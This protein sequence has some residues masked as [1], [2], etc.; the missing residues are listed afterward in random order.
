MPDHATL[1]GGP[2]GG[3][4]VEIIGI[5]HEQHVSTEHGDITAV[6]EWQCDWDHDGEKF[7]GIFNG[8]FFAGTRTR[9]KKDGSSISKELRKIK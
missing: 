7:L 8:Y 2:W 4:V 6:Y 5:R 1:R 9:C 3:Q